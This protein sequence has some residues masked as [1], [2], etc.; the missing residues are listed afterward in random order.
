MM[1]N[2]MDTITTLVIATLVTARIT[3]LVTAD[4]ITRAP[5]TWVLRR[6]PSDSLTAY[7]IVCTWCTSVY[8]GLAVAATGAMAGAWT[9]PWVVPLGLA[10]SHVSGLMARGEAD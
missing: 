7:F 10:F 9:W 2:N 3:R 8:T 6:L 5:R 4:R 1:G